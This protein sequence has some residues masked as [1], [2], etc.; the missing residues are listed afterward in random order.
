VPRGRLRDALGA[1]RASLLS[2]S[3]TAADRL[4]SVLV[5][6]Q[7]AGAVVLLIGAGLLTRSF[8]KLMSVDTGYRADDT[9]TFQI[10]ADEDFFRDGDRQLAYYRDLMDRIAAH[11]GVECVGY[12]SQLPLLGG[13]NWGTVELVG[14]PRASDPAEWPRTHHEVVSADYFRTVG[15][16]LLK[17]RDF[18]PAD[19]QHAAYVAIVNDDFARRYLGSLDAIGVELKYGRNTYTVVGVVSGKRNAGPGAE[20]RPEMF[21]PLPQAPP[22]FR[23]I[24][25]A[26]GFA[27]RAS[28]DPLSLVPYIREQAR[29]AD[30]RSPVHNIMTLEDRLWRATGQPRFHA[31]AVGAF[32]MFALI[33]AMLGV[34]GVL[35]YAVERR[36]V[37]FGVRRALGADAAQIIQLVLRRGL[38]LAAIGL[39]IG[40]LAAAL[41]VK[42]LRSLLFGVEP[43]D[44]ATFAAVAASVLF[45]A[46]LAS[47][48]PAR[49]ATR[50]QPTEALRAD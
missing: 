19:D 31:A 20:P 34:Y 40:L 48:V 17:G 10:K 41:S 11:P 8:E 44:P 46:A 6:A 47:I 14:L 28:V 16:P 37:E 12:S 26:G 21:V 33:T 25:A 24:G 36:R 2:R 1:G 45:V 35:A 38:G 15:V 3:V 4:R 43:G 18:T 32:S 39:P 42:L 22:V 30:P 50:V 5:V 23:D 29:V 13:R 27:V 7:I 49:R 9:L